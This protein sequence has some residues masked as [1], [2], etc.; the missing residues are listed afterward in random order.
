VNFTGLSMI[1]TFIWSSWE[2][3]SNR[4][5]PK[6]GATAS[7]KS[8]LGSGLIVVWNALGGFRACVSYLRIR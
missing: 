5:T 4:L 6:S 8:K 3:Y 7:A 2:R 1:A